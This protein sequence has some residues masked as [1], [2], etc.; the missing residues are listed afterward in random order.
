MA[1]LKETIARV[2]RDH[3][4]AEGMNARDLYGDLFQ[5]RIPGIGEV[6]RDAMIAA[7]DAGLVKPCPNNGGHRF[8]ALRYWDQF[9]AEGADSLESFE[10][11]HLVRP[12]N[13]HLARTYKDWVHDPD[14]VAR[15][16]YPD[17]PIIAAAIMEGVEKVEVVT[18]DHVPHL[19]VLLAKELE[20][21]RSR[22]EI[23]GDHAKGSGIDGRSLVLRFEGWQ[24]VLYEFFPD[25]TCMRPTD[26]PVMAPPARHYVIDTGGKLLVLDGKDHGVESF[27]T[28]MLKVNEDMEYVEISHDRGLNDSI[29]ATYAATGFLEIPLIERFPSLVSDGEVV[30][31][32][33]LGE[34]GVPEGLGMIQP[35]SIDHPILVCLDRARALAES[36]GMD[37]DQAME[38]IEA[39]CATVLEFAPGPLHIYAPDG[40]RATNF[41]KDFR[42]YGIGPIPDGKDCFYISEQS[43][44]ADAPC[45]DVVMPELPALEK[46]APIE[47]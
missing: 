5:E 3:I 34:D 38:D 46:S 21:P 15:K 24:P 32:C 22:P 16:E 19:A 4:P 30:R 14:G 28:A 27:V 1:D 11:K 43:L 7:R 36:L 47:P 25:Y 13:Q 33:S 35:Y 42:P 8:S 23:S 39:G 17:M 40:W 6:V 26:L 44:E 41:D 29:L 45:L 2:L 37:P 18:L 12:L 31:G 20:D 10:I 9:I